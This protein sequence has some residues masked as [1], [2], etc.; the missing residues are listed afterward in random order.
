MADNN[1][2]TTSGAGFCLQES[3]FAIV[4]ARLTLREH[5]AGLAMQ[6]LMANPEY[7]AETYQ[8]AMREA[9]N[10]ADALIV[11]L[12]REVIGEPK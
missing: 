2:S 3:T 10:N 9:V 12:N 11:E 7:N 5:F 8:S 1:N 4:A 6:G